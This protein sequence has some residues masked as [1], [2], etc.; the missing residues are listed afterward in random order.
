MAGEMIQMLMSD[1]PQL[2]QKALHTIQTVIAKS[3]EEDKSRQT[4][5]EIKRRFVIIEM[6]IRELRTDHGWAFQRIFDVLQVALR[7]KL[8]GIPWQPNSHR[9]LWTPS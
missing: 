8:D 9:T 6:L 7:C 5:A 3:F 1:D 2:Q 4:G